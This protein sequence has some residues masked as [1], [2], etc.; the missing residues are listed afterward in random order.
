[1]LLNVYKITFDVWRYR[2]YLPKD[3][4][5]SY[6]YEG[7]VSSMCNT[8][9]LSYEHISNTELNHFFPAMFLGAITRK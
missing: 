5:P 3:L 4:P 9:V 2:V 6:Q 1:M 7:L 8:A